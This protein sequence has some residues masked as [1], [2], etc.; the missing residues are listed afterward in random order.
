MF[1]NTLSL[2]LYQDVARVQRII[3]ESKSCNA[4]RYTHVVMKSLRTK[5]QRNVIGAI[6]VDQKKVTNLKSAIKS[7]LMTA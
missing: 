7:T 3:K 6:S 4:P 1:V 5:I 2:F